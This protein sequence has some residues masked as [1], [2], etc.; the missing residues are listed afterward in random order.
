MGTPIPAEIILPTGQPAYLNPYKG[1]YTTSRPYAIR[2]QRNY[3]RGILQSE[4]RGH[5]QSPEGF[6]ESQLRRQRFEIN[7]GIPY[8]EWERWRRKYVN[9]INVRSWPTGPNTRY[10][11]VNEGVRQDPRVYPEDLAAIK[12]AY[13]DGYRDPAM[14]NI[15]YQEWIEIRLTERLSAMI[16]FQDF[17]DSTPGRNQYN[18]RQGAWTAQGMWTG[19]FSVA[20]GPPLE[21]WYYH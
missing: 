1:T 2:M 20:S 15:S 4:A 21:L 6:T 16:A 18:S 17:K 7:R 13:D 14:P 9:E 19:V 11:V 10:P 5:R 3:A 12:Q 8:R